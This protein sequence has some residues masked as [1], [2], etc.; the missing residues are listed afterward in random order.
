MIPRRAFLCGTAA[1]LAAAGAD[2]KDSEDISPTEDLMREH[3]VLRR[4]LLVY[5][6]VIR[7]LDGREAVPSTELKETAQL[8]RSFVEDYHEKDEE[9]FIFPRM[10]KAGQH[11][12][13][14]ETLLKQHQA[15]RRVTADILRLAGGGARG[16]LRQTLIAF[17]RMYQPHAA[18]EDTILFP[19]FRKL[20]SEKELDQLGDEFEKRER[21]I[22]HGDG[23]DQGVATVTRI[24]KAL[25]I[26]DL[27]QFTPK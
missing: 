14:V 1:G 5:G 4:S 19:A 3:G 27:N 10:R 26:Y 13:L 15:G 25:G 7:R 12:D 20:L 23:F 11:V 22:F 8:I 2:K 21:Q 18:R 16:E 17:I 24:E 6:E 9:D